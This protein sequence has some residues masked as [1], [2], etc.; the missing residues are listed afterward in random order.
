M[1]FIADLSGPDVEG[2]GPLVRNIRNG[3]RCSTY[4]GYIEP[5]LGHRNLTVLTGAT[6]QKLLISNTDCTGV[7]VA[8]DGRLLR[9]KSNKETVLS[10]GSYDTPRILMLSG[11]GPQEELLRLGIKT[12]ANLIG[13]GQNLHDHPTVAA[14]M[15]ERNEAGAPTSG[16]SMAGSG[17]HWKS[18][19]SKAVPDLMFIPP[20][21]PIG[22]PDVCALYPPN[23]NTFS[24]MPA[25]MQPV[26]RG[27][28]KMLTA[29]PDGP[30]E[31]QP[32]YL[33]EPED[34]A[35]MV[36][37]VEIALELADQPAYRKMIKK[38][39]APAAISNKQQIIDFLK[40]ATA[41]YWHPVG[42]CAMGK[43]EH[44]VVDNLLRVHGIGNLRIA[45]ASIMPKI[46]SASTNAPTVMIGEFAA[47]AILGN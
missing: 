41:S 44:A 32:N 21:F 7:E 47:Q 27:Y 18:E 11:I 34:M 23:E 45:D 12:V 17:I 30:L 16:P 8:V 14:L 6:V 33:A 29:K 5:I 31:I 22:S 42:T 38:M 10:A 9:I 26:S 3:K 43:G 39:I 40:I 36:R 19:A 24:I 13:V 1:P 25:L 2:V 4:T 37:A 15:F 28:L 46:T 35:A 20:Q